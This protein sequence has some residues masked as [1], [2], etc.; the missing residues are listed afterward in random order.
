MSY[1]SACAPFR[2]RDRTCKRCIS[3]LLGSEKEG[4]WID[5]RVRPEILTRFDI[6]AHLLLSSNLII[7]LR[8]HAQIIGSIS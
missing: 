1:F 6:H 8:L 7:D 5:L 3:S 2:I 4:F